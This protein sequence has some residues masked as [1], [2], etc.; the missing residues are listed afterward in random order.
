M[1]TFTVV[2]RTE[3]EIEAAARAELATYY[4]ELTSDIWWRIH[5]EGKSLDVSTSRHE[6]LITGYEATIEAGRKAEWSKGGQ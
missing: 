2:G 4:G 5:A 6:T 1:I 3:A